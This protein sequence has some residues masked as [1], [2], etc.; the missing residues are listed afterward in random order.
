VFVDMMF[1]DHW[2]G[3]SDDGVDV[4]DP[5]WAVIENAIRGLNGKDRTLVMLSGDG[6]GHLA[7]GGGTDGQYLVYGTVDNLSFQVM[8][9]QSEGAELVPLVA[10]GQEGE[11]PARWLTQLDQALMAAKLYVHDGLLGTTGSWEPR[12]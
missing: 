12:R 6:A 1:A 11:Y 10:G 7:I 3:T 9:N 8:V 2:Q 5:T 4:A